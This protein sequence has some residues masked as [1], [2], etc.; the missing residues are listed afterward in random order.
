MSAERADIRQWHDD[1]AY[2]AAK[3]DGA[4]ER[5][6]DY[7]GITVTIR[8]GAQVNAALGGLISHT[9]ATT[10]KSRLPQCW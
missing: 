5:G 3:R 6:F 7:L 1:A 8:G 2:E 10:D 9:T 4:H